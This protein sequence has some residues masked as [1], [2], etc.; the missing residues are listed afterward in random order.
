MKNFKI[1]LLILIANTI[2]LACEP[3]D[4]FVS[5]ILQEDGNFVDKNRQWLIDNSPFYLMNDFGENYAFSVS[6]LENNRLLLEE[7][8]DGVLYSESSTWNMR[9]SDRTRID[10]ITR[11]ENRDLEKITFTGFCS[12]ILH[13]NPNSELQFV[14]NTF[15]AKQTLED[16][17]KFY[18][19]EAHN[20]IDWFISDFAG[21]SS[22][23]VK[24]DGFRYGGYDNTIEL[25]PLVGYTLMNPDTGK[26][27]LYNSS[28]FDLESNLYNP[29]FQEIKYSF[30]NQSDTYLTGLR[31]F[32]YLDEWGYINLSIKYDANYSPWYGIEFISANNPEFSLLPDDVIQRLISCNSTTDPCDELNCV[33]GTKETNDNGDCYCECDTGWTGPNCDQQVA[34]L[35]INMQLLAGNGTQGNAN[36]TFGQLNY[37]QAMTTS[38]DGTTVYIAD[39]GSKSI[40]IVN[41]INNEVTTLLG[42]NSEG[43]QDGAYADARFSSFG[44]IAL[45]DVGNIYVSDA[46]NHVI[47]K[48]ANGQVTTYAGIGAAGGFV[49][50]A[51]SIAQF[52]FPTGLLI[53]NNIMYVA[54]TENG[55]IRAITMNDDPNLRIVSTYAG[56]GTIN[57]MDGANASAA[58][59]GP[60][61]V[62][63][64]SASDRLLVTDSN[65]F[66][67][68]FVRAVTN[69]QTSTLTIDLP[70]SF[71]LGYSAGIA[72]DEVANDGSFY[73]TDRTNHT[74]YHLND[75]GGVYATAIVTA[76][77]YQTAGNIGGAPGVSRLNF[78]NL[79]HIG[80]SLNSNSQLET[81][82][83]IANTIG[84]SVW[85]IPISLQ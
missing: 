52:R 74:L 37:P 39:G 14:Q 61:D 77:Q 12:P 43:Y 75:V 32:S 18:R 60:K 25:F 48:I 33:N 82:L 65:A 3:V 69:T 34:T 16:N 58:F 26:I 80:T 13:L 63:Y 2:F 1:V 57:L 56:N 67:S 45:D 78:P 46:G 19:L 9:Y 6:F 79:L 29:D 7:C 72:M 38:A 17:G 64:D 51:V 23:K 73:V 76:G 59:L 31:S 81:R 11:I 44:D 10:D 85:F 24:L 41:P 53:R 83:Y 68:A 70:G 54:D 4:T 15:V 49:D 36:G 71:I 55:S 30:L 28:V 27:D 35:P 66:G 47:R 84:Q 40:R 42:G 50:G 62:A 5:P 8:R 22:P 20:P 21:A